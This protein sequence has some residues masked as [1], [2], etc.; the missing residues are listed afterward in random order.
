[1]A[2]KRRPRETMSPGPLWAELGRRFRLDG[3]GPGSPAFDDGTAADKSAN[4]QDDRHGTWFRHGVHRN[5]IEQGERGYLRGAVCKERQH[6]TGTSCSEVECLLHPAAKTST[7]EIIGRGRLGLAAQAHSQRLRGCAAEARL[8]R[9]RPVET[10]RIRATDG[11]TGD[12]L[13]KRTL[14][15]GTIHGDEVATVRAGGQAT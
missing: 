4:N 3:S 1:M 15:E 7:G 13:R 9:S 12:V 5:P 2:T 8:L 14:L 6:F 10:D 11:Q